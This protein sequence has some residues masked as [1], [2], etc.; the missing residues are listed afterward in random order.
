MTSTTIHYQCAWNRL[1]DIEDD[2]IFEENVQER[3]LWATFI[4]TF[5]Q[6]TFNP[7]TFKDR[8]HAALYS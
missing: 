1:I 7:L 8:N 5:N 4:V 6:P 3:L 2:G